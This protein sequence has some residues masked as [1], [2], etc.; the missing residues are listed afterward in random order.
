LPDLRS[1]VAVGTGQGQGL[2]NID[3]GE[4]SGSESVTILSTQMSPHVHAMGG[5][6]SEPCNT[7]SGSNP[8]PANAYPA[9]V[10]TDR[11]ATTSAGNM[12]NA[13]VNVT[14][15]LTGQNNPID[16]IQPYLAIN[17]IIAVEGIYPSRN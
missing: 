10:G 5:T 3:L 12:L 17:F 7:V 14:L 13:V 4:I 15:G 2:P 11:Y 1:R 16:I 8:D 6:C 9:P